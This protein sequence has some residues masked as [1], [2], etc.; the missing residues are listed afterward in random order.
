MSRKSDILWGRRDDYMAWLVAADQAE[1]KG[2]TAYAEYLRHVGTAMQAVI[3][4]VH[5]AM[6]EGGKAT[7][8]VGEKEFH[9]KACERIVR[10]SIIGRGGVGRR[11]NFDRFII[12]RPDY[13]P[14]RVRGLI[15]EG[16]F[17]G[18]ESENHERRPYPGWRG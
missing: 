4:T 10:L 3:E 16:V 12:F 9:V 8:K 13:L 2:E 1:E 17:D 18:Q 7:G 14:G 6:H 5:K 11:C 15:K